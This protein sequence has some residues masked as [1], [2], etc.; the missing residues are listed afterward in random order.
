[1]ADRK[2]GYASEKLFGRKCSFS[3][4]LA[5]NGG[6]GRVL[7]RKQIQTAYNNIRYISYKLIMMTYL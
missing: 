4:K 1:M 7:H 5:M 6:E 2:C 3:S